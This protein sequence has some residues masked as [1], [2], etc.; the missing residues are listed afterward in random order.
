MW[1]AVADCCLFSKT[2][3][4]SHTPGLSIDQLS[5][6]F[7]KLER[8]LS[9]PGGYQTV[10]PLPCCY[11]LFI[12]L[13]CCLSAAGGYQTVLPFP[14][15]FGS[16]VRHVVS[17]ALTGPFSIVGMLP[18]L[19][20]LFFLVDVLRTLSGFFS[21]VDMLPGS[22][23]SGHLPFCCLLLGG[24]IVLISCCVFSEVVWRS[25]VRWAH[26][27]PCIAGDLLVPARSHSCCLYC[28]Y[29]LLRFFYHGQFSRHR[30]C[31]LGIRSRS[32]Y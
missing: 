20:G 19:R 28:A 22:P 8:C 7:I 30:P 5:C 16:Q 23:L 32:A 6:C 3:T 13:E 25:V 4:V 21:I 12:K 17:S 1:V 18:A 9:T 10:L 11:L 14:C 24:S 2:K 26:W 27:L 15:C 31:S 29:L